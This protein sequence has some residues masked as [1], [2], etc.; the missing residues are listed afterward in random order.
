VDLARG[1]G[2]RPAARGVG[3]LARWI[4]GRLTAMESLALVYALG[5]VA[6]GLVVG[7]RVGAFVVT[8]LGLTVLLALTAVLLIRVLGLS[9]DLA[10]ALAGITL[11]FIVYSA[12]PP[13]LDLRMDARVDQQLWD[14]ERALLGTTAVE[15][16]E[17]YTATGLTALFGLVYALHVPL[18][19]VPAILHW[20]AG[21]RDRAE[22]LLL[23]LALQMYLGFLGYALWPALGPVGTIEGLRPLGDN[24][25]LRVVAD[26]GVDLGTFPSI[27]AAICA[28]VALDAWRTSRVWGVVFTAIAAGIWASTLYLRYHWVPDLF[29]GLALSV[30]AYWLSGK[31]RHARE[32]RG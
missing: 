17:P 1:R 18:F 7:G 28:T 8:I 9:P 15:M 26:Y 23:A 31:I 29:A 14:V 12:L 13:L 10:R 24:P 16:I 25:T 19:F 4:P 3:E 11:T 20:W 6:V 21:R 30:F 5:G 27:H 2:A 22:R 32:A